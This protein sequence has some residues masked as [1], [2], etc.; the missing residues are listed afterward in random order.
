MMTDYFSSIRLSTSRWASPLWQHSH[1][2]NPAMKILTSAFLRAL[3]L[4]VLVLP[5]ISSAQQKTIVQLQTELVSSWLVTVEGEE[6]TR[7]L[8]ISGASQKSGDELL[9][10]AV[11]GWTDGNHTAISASLVQSG[12]DVKLLFT[13]QPGSKVAA[14][15]TS[16]GI[17]EGTFTATNGTIKPVKIEKVSD[18]SLQARIAAAKARTA[19]V[20]V[21]PG[22]N[23]P[24]ECAAFSGR[25]TGDW[26]YYGRKWLW[27]VEVSANCVAKCRGTTTSAAPSTY[28]S[29]EIKDNVLVYQKQDGKEY[30]EHRGDELWARYVYSGGQNNAVYRK[31]KPGEN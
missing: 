27:V 10:E 15:Q 12:Q 25:W 21:E 18:E 1:V 11:Y 29:C 22:P 30:Y 19:G 14:L 16:N 6:R 13:T 20:I 26:P 23:V 28:Q 3:C 2:R 5:G 9:L 17:F 4:V 7:T 31:L 24:K 8:R